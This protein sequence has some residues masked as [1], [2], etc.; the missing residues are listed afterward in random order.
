MADNHTSDSEKYYS[1]F[2]KPEELRLCEQFLTNGY[3]IL[4]VEDRPALDKIRGEFADRAAEFLQIDKPKDHGQFLNEI[5]NR[6]GFEKLNEFR[7]FLFNKFN[8]NAWARSAYFSLARNALGTLVGN[9]L[10]MQKRINLS[11]QLPNDDSSLLPIHSDVW[12]GD[13]PFEVVLWLPLVDCYKTKSMYILPPKKNA[14]Y[15]AKFSNFKSQ[16]SEDLYKAVEPHLQWLD[17]PYGHCLLFAHTLMHGNRVNVEKETRWS[18]NCRFK[19]LFSPY[20][21]K[22]LGEFFEPITIRPLSRIGMEYKLPEGF[23]E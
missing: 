12:S 2:F 13:S 9:E 18:M 14:E 15:E 4:P 22:R 10:A 1:G 19:G 23:K 20:W 7:L 21:D 5:A 6:I 16:S 11:I 8:S 17:V 3:V